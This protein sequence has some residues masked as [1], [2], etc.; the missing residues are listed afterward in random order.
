MSMS[1]HLQHRFEAFSLDASFEVPQ[2]ITVLYGRSGSGKTSI[3]NAVAGL[4]RPATGRIKVGDWTLFDSETGTC[5]PPHKRRIGYIFQEGRLFPHLTVAQNL[6][7][8]RWFAPK[9]ARVEN[10][11]HIVDMLGIG[12]LL[13]RRPARLSGG[14]KQ[15]V[16]IGRA[17][18]SGP[19][20]IL[21][22]EPL[23]ALDPARKEE[24]LPYFQR[25]RDEVDVPILYVSHAASEVT[26]L[27]TTVVA[28]E[29]G[30]M[31]KQ[32]PASVVLSDPQVTPLGAG[33]AGAFLD[34]RVVAHHTDGISEVEAGGL[35][36]LLPPIEFPLGTAL[37]IRI[38]AQDVTLAL[39][40]PK[41]ISALNVLPATVTSMRKGDGPG[42]LVQLRAGDNLLL[43]RITRRSADALRIAPGTEVFAI[44]KAV[45]I[46]RSGMGDRRSADRSD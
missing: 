22:D 16:A 1:V 25:L 41:D 20:L 29:A 19:R 27:A 32:G 17:L 10:M 26:R 14:E 40:R 18:L 15:R 8:G 3:V 9:R 23:A 13:D 7:Y 24:I 11:D 33:A 4:L 46:P 2:G 35:R 38:E 21:A 42:A 12:A 39:Q 43:S 28:L 44:L 6:E 45:S 30:R 34:A 36:L 5:L 37:R 31:I